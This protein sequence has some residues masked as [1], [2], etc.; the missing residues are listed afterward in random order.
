MV[1][2][3][4]GYACASSPQNEI[5]PDIHSRPQLFHNCLLQ[6]INP[7]IPPLEFPAVNFFRFKE[8]KAPLPTC[9][10]VSLT[11]FSEG[12]KYATL[13]CL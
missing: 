7:K 10:F 1:G 2:G 4:G 12:L 9:K 6:G 3:P 11:N 13:A 5:F 8:I